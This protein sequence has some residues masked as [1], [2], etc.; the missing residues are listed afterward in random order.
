MCERET[1]RV[2]ER[3]VMKGVTRMMHTKNEAYCE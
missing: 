1:E 2:R 3:R